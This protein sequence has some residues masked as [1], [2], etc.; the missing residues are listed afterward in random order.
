MWLALTLTGLT[1]A[2]EVPAAW[3]DGL[4]PTPF[5]ASAAAATWRVV[6]GA[7]GTTHL[8]DVDANV[9]LWR[10]NARDVAIGARAGVRA[11]GLDVPAELRGHFGLRAIPVELGVTAWRS[12]GRVWV[13]H[14]AALTLVTAPVPHGLAWLD[15]RE[16]DGGVG[17]GYA[18]RVQGPRFDVGLRLDL[19]LA[20]RGLAAEPSLPPAFQPLG[21]VRLAASGLGLPTRWLAVGAGVVAGRTPGVGFGQVILRGRPTEGVELGLDL[22]VPFQ[23]ILPLVE[24]PIWPSISV[25]FTERV[26]PATPPPAP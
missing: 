5:T 20:A 12:A 18:C 21:N 24:S 19:G 16:L 11:T 10:T 4:A 14:D 8:L 2:D 3:S 26:R 1:L 13:R 17:L 25:R 23:P 7:A 6:P 9:A 15:G 22:T